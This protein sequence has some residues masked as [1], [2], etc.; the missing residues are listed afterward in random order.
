MGVAIYLI[1]AWSDIPDQVPAQYGLG[2]E[3]TRMDSKNSLWIMPGIALVIFVSLIIIERFPKLW[4]TGVRVTEENK[5]RVYGVI[6]S[7][8][9]SVKLILVAVF[10]FITIFT[11]LSQ[12]M[13]VWF[14]IVFALLLLISPIFHIILLFKVR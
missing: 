7:L 5:F 13:P 8:L 11:S 2:G 12:S 14:M 10:V 6:K 9:G 1:A 3:V 4:N